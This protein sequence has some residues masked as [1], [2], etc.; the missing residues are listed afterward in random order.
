MM[1]SVVNQLEDL[2]TRVDFMVAGYT[3]TLQV[4]DVGVNRPFKTYMS[5]A[6]NERM[7]SSGQQL[8]RQNVH[9]GSSI[10]GTV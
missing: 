6:Y 9:T 5:E 2:G 10:H 1:G 7:I 3:S 4:L 8:T